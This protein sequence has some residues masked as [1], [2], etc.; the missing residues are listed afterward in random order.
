MSIVYCWSVYGTRSF[1]WLFILPASPGMYKNRVNH[2]IFTISTTTWDVWNPTGNG[3][4]YIPVNWWVNPGFLVAINS[5]ARRKIR[6]IG[7][8]SLAETFGSH[9]QYA[10]KGFARGAWQHRRCCRFALRGVSSR[11]VW[12]N[13]EAPWQLRRRFSAVWGVEDGCWLRWAEIIVPTVSRWNKIVSWP[14]LLKFAF[15]W[16]HD[17]SCEPAHDM[18]KSKYEWWMSIITFCKWF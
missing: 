2:R 13:G 4:N 12:R 15:S 16:E 17:F 18:M 6:A 3:I 5:M 10:A 14:C 8:Q 9:S 11:G 1:C 7:L